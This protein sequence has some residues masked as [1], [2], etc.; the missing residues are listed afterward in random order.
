MNTQTITKL[1]NM[2]GAGM[3]DCKKAL[4]ETNGDIEKAIDY[5]RKKGE[6]KAA[7]KSA[8]RDASEGIIHSYIHAGGKVGVMIQ[9]N[10][11]TDFVA[12]NADFQELAHNLAMHIAAA[13]PSY[14]KQ[15]D[16]PKEELEKEK[17]IY[18][19]QLKTEGKPE[20]IIEKILDGK[21]AK[22]YE[23]VCLLK[24]P[25]IKDDKK[26]VEHIISEV[27]AK[28]GEKIEV[29]KFARYQI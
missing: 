21:I 8:E 15:E 17:D 9:L 22:Y 1:R 19:E 2:T 14:V 7:K 25:F 11:E 24:Q 29:A 28:I 10:C 18:R 3:L 26:K 13:N 5:L 4:D 20:N 23:E 12:R 16:V 6:I 27:I